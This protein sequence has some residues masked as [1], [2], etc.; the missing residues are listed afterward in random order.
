MFKLTILVIIKIIRSRLSAVA[1][2]PE[3][4]YRITDLGREALKS[5]E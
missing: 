5:D 4:R 3:W 2:E 1:K